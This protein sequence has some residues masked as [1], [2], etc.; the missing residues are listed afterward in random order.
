MTGPLP[1]RWLQ[2]TEEMLNEIKQLKREYNAV[3][4]SHYYMPAALQVLEKDGGVADFTGDSLGLSLKAM[5]TDAEHIIFCGVEFMAET[6]FILNPDKKVLI[7]SR[8]AGCSL[9]SSINGEQVRMLKSKHPGVPV[10]AYINTYAETKAECDVIC[11]SRNALK[12]AEK[13]EGDRLIFVPDKY[14]GANLAGYFRKAGKELILWNGACEVHEQF[15][16]NIALLSEDFPNAEVLLHWEVPAETVD[17]SFRNRKGALGSTS[18]LIRYVGESDSRQFILG[19]E[20]DLGATLK[21]LYP[22]KEFITPCISCRYMKKIN[23]K[24]TLESLRSIGTDQE[25]KYT[26]KLDESL[27]ERAYRPLK[28]MLD[29][30]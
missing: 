4:L 30:G 7:P 22:E 13:L 5:N 17:K 8:E 20:C 12:I 15:R 10:M 16:E 26:V 14:M 21:G 9:A 18:D 29:L 25:E 3:V 2:D 1:Q 24:N 6:A 28:K 11:T 27:R 23:V 19:S